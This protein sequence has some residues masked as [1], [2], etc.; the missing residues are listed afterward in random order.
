MHG[1]DVLQHGW[2]L[3]ASSSGQAAPPFPPDLPLQPPL[4][5]PEAPSAPH[6]VCHSD[7]FKQTRLGLIRLR[8]RFLQRFTGAGQRK[9][10]GRQQT[11]G[12]AGAGRDWIMGQGGEGK[13]GPPGP[14]NPSPVQSVLDAIPGSKGCGRCAVWMDPG[15]GSCCHLVHREL[16]P[17]TPFLNPP[18]DGPKGSQ[19]PQGQHGIM[20]VRRDTGN[21]QQ[22]KPE[23]PIY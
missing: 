3:A 16:L 10:V 21:N 1:L 14:S 17:H 6:I 2:E 9:A 18:K 20:P 13:Q 12:Q 19:E 23:P 15:P 7:R 8:L 22:V 5:H 11:G 4:L